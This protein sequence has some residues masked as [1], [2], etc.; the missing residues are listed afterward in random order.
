[1]FILGTANFGNSYPGSKTYLDEFK[2]YQVVEKFVEYG[3]TQL[4]SAD[5][6][7]ESLNIIKSWK[8]EVQFGD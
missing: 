7:G 8:I 4:D 6:Y 5:A 1:M 2:A 3:G